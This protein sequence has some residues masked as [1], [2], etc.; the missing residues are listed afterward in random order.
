MCS[1]RIKKWTRTTSLLTAALNKRCHEYSFMYNISQQYRNATNC[2]K[3]FNSN[4]YSVTFLLIH[5]RTNSVAEPPV[6]DSKRCCVN[7]KQC[8]VFNQED[9]VLIKVLRQE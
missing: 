1:V 8:M 3:V 6:V 7:S 4:K 2:R 9:K 5:L